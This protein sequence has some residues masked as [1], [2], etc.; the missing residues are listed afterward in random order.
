VHSI[1]FNGDHT[2]DMI[3]FITRLAQLVERVAFN[4]KARGSTPL[5]GKIKAIKTMIL[6]AFVAQWIERPPSKR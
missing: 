6:I 3:G 4:H 1:V 5:T 2:F